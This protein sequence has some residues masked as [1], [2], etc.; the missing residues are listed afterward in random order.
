LTIKD[1]YMGSK[2]LYSCRFFY[3]KNGK[4]KSKYKQGFARK[5]EAEQWGIDEKRRLEGIHAGY[6]SIRVKDFLEQWIE[7]KEDKL[8]PTTLSGYKVNIKHINEHIGNMELSKVNLLHVQNMLDTLRKKYKYRTV[9]YVYRTLHAA[10]NYALKIPLV[11][12]NVC[13]GAEIAEDDKKFEINVYSAADLSK[14]LTVLKEQEHFLYYLVL[15]AGMR[16]LRRGE[17]LGLKW[18]DFDGG[19][20]NIK[21]NYV[22]A[23]K[24]EYHRKVKTRDSERRVDIEGIIQ[25]EFEAFKEKQIREGRIQTYVFEEGGRLPNP[26]HISRTLKTFQKAN[27]LPLCRFHDLRHTFA[28]LQ[29]EHGTD[30]D[31]LKR[32]LGHSKVGITS[33]TYLHENETLIKKAS[34]A[35]DNTIFLKCHNKVTINR[36]KQKAS[37]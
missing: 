8:S 13:I 6:E 12:K 9:K 20:I 19:I 15:L 16:G 29:L 23:N 17:C 30:I 18:S 1:Y 21:N 24:K 36:E 3:Y 4:K 37:E 27:N 11:E 33:D 26:T 25:Q 28:V 32:L 7:I 10:L 14:L 31:T 35:L 22:V 2:K 34:K 5:K